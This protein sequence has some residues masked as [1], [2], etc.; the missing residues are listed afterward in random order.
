MP[1]SRLVE[2]GAQSEDPSIASDARALQ[3]RLAELEQA[4]QEVDR[5]YL[6]WADLEAKRE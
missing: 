6:R 5:L 3:I 2:V 4:K 1:T